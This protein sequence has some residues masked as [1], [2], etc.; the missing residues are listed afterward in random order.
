MLTSSRK[1]Q[2]ANQGAL[3][4]FGTLLAS[5]KPLRPKE[6]GLLLFKETSMKCVTSQKGPEQSFVAKV[7]IVSMISSR[8]Q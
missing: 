7:Q 8:Q 2:K 5:Q 1:R 3:W 4:L 6:R